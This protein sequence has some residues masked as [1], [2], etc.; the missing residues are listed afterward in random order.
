VCEFQKSLRRADVSIKLPMNA[1]WPSCL[2]WA[3]TPASAFFLQNEAPG[4]TQSNFSNPVQ[5]WQFDTATGSKTM[6]RLSVNAPLQFVHRR[7]HVSGVFA[8]CRTTPASERINS[9]QLRAMAAAKGF[10]VDP[11]DTVVEIAPMSVPIST[12]PGWRRLLDRLYEGDTLV[13]PGLDSLGRE[14][15]EVRATIMLLVSRGIRVHCLALGRMNLAGPE[16]KS[17]LEMLAAV[18]ALEQ[19]FKLDH[20]RSRRSVPET[21]MAATRGR[22]LSLSPAQVTEAHNLSG[23]GVSVVQIAKRLQTSRQTVMRL[24]ARRKAG[25]VT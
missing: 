6:A 11:D 5:N 9:S 4:E 18:V 25:A 10:A 16:G 23:A 7:P 22:P 19:G 3:R 1:C 14:V 8:Y 17:A 2:P 21:E 20:L 24:L 15:V 13:V 12:H